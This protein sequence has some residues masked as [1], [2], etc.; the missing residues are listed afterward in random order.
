MDESV[1]SDCRSFTDLVEPCPSPEPREVLMDV[2]FSVSNCYNASDKFPVERVPGEVVI[3]L[4]SD[5]S[6][7]HN[8]HVVHDR[9]FLNLAKP[10]KVLTLI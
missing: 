4:R 2:T 6:L 1:T 5:D 8:Q 7:L 9:Q 10:R 3:T